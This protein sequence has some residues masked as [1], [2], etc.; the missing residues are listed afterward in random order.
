MQSNLIFLKKV[1]A[2]PGYIC[3]IGRSYKREYCGCLTTIL[4][5][6]DDHAFAPAGRQCGARRL[7][8]NVRH[9]AARGS[10]TETQASRAV[11]DRGN[12]YPGLQIL[13][14]RTLLVGVEAGRIRRDYDD[15]GCGLHD[16]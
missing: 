13:V 1:T 16:E 11:A 5:Y 14:Q 3:C 7:E 10:P 9:A 2:T 8:G 15:F 6:S 12:T 4:W